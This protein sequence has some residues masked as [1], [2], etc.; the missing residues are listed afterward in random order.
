MNC[1]EES[2]FTSADDIRFSFGHFSGN[3]DPLKMS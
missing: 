2:V 3:R 1:A